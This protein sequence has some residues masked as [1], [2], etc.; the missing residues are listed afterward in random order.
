[1]E[2]FGCWSSWFRLASEVLTAGIGT[3]GSGK[4][5]VGGNAAAVLVLGGISGGSGSGGG[6]GG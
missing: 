4:H 2:H 5:L 3:C 6:G 1:M